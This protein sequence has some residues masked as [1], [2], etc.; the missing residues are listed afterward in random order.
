[1]F[2]ECQDPRY[3]SMN[4]FNLLH[5]PE[6]VHSVKFGKY[7]KNYSLIAEKFI[8]YISVNVKKEEMPQE[9][10]EK[11]DFFL[12]KICMIIIHAVKSG[13]NYEQ[14]NIFFKLKYKIK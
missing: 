7:G 4:Y 13:D 3:F 6:M 9:K 11:L 10:K 2:T 14:L 1:M 12:S 8:Y 5:I